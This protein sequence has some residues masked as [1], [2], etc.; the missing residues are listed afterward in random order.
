RARNGQRPDGH[1]PA[2]GIARLGRA[3]RGPR[4]SHRHGHEVVMKH[5]AVVA[6]V[7]VL[8]ASGAAA[9]EQQDDQLASRTAEIERAQSEKS[10]SLAPARPGKIE[11]YV[12]R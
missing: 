2:A 1:H 3:D 7:V 4:W 5:S 8:V 6:V 9:Q 10:A 11:A 12:A